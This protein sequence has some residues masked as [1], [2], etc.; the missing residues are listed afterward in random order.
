MTRTATE[1]PS[2]PE[3]PSHDDTAATARSE[4]H[5]HLKEALSLLL[6]AHDYALELG[7]DDWDMAV[8]LDA[9]RTARLTN[10][11]LRWL[12]AKG[13][14]DH[15]V[16]ATAP[17]DSARHFRHSPL[18][19][20]SGPTCVVLTRS[21]ASIAR[22]ALSCEAASG[23]AAPRV[24]LCQLATADELTERPKWD[25]QRRQLRVGRVLVKEFKLPSPNQETVLMAFEEEGWPPR[26][27]DPLPPVAQLDPRRRLHDTI[28]AL[29]R[30]QKR[31]LIR[32]RGDG[33]GEGIR[34][35]PIVS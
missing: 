34:W 18:L 17:G 12:L 6:Q 33:S 13:L 15:A 24:G 26:I 19:S 3:A 32:F 25:E 7:Q 35:E 10:S 14:I 31:D 5:P 4:I 16:E 29:N 22:E 11:D 20:F 21:G 30:K 8:E 2:R 28:K 1:L 9:L 23:T 27:D